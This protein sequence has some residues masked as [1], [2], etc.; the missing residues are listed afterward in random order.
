LFFFVGIAESFCHHI[1]GGCWIWRLGLGGGGEGN[2]QL[3]IMV[4][5][6]LVSR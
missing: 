4:G 3:V 5:D 1:V 2:V 6:G